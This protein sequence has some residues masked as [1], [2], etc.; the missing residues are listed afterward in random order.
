MKQR[1][2][3]SYI[4]IQTMSLS[5]WNKVYIK[6]PVSKLGQ[7]KVDVLQLGVQLMMIVLCKA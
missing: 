1:K 4:Q 3:L 7:V 2:V 6:A 5:I